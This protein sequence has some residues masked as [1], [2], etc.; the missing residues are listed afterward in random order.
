MR[1]RIRAKSIGAVAAR[2]SKSEWRGLVSSWL[3]SGQTANQFCESRGG[4]RPGTLKWW[5]WNLGHSTSVTRQSSS[6]PV[7]NFLPVR[8]VAAELSP[9][10]ST[11]MPQPTPIEVVVRGQ[12]SIRIHGEFDAAVLQQ[13][14]RA[15]EE[16]D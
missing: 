4:I 7:T 15:L 13:V 3:S 1:R 12:R 14:V 5:A 10:P 2:R 11:A 8:I 6:Q 9:R 16:I